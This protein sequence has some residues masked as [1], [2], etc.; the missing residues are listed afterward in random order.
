M[1]D[2]GSCRNACATLTFIAHLPPLE[3]EG[4]EVVG[5]QADVQLHG[6]DHLGIHVPAAGEADLENWV[7]GAGSKAVT[8][9]RVH[10]PASQEPTDG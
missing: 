3:V 6:D 1:A 8:T 5:S 2:E 9:V 10:L 7:G 4:C